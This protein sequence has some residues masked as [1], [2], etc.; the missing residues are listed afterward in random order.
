MSYNRKS[1]F[2][3]NVQEF[4]LAYFYRSCNVGPK[5]ILAIPGGSSRSIPIAGQILMLLPLLAV[6]RS[7]L[8]N[9]LFTGAAHELFHVKPL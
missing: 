5:T 2:R 8:G 4:V 7:V 1:I 6:A 3:L 9:S